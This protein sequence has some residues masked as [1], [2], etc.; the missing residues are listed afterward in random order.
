[1]LKKPSAK[2]RAQMKRRRLK[3]GLNKTEKKETKKIVDAAIKKQHVLKYFNSS[4]TN[5][6]AAISPQITTVGNNKEVSVVA[7]SSTTEFDNQGAAIK[8]GPARS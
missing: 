8:F 5:G 4:S 7:F 3:A 6:D 2:M 1:M